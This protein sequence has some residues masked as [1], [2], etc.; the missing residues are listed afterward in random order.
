MFK[1]TIIR[2][3]L[4]L[5]CSVFTAQW[6]KTVCLPD[7]T[8]ASSHQVPLSYRIQPA[9]SPKYKQTHNKT[10]LIHKLLQ[11]ALSTENGSLACVQFL[12]AAPPLKSQ[13]DGVLFKISTSGNELMKKEKEIFLQITV[14]V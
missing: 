2:P 11:Q 3:F 5:H 1:T 10:I 9:N 12:L 13:G 8:P 7:E 14:S 4:L 6:S